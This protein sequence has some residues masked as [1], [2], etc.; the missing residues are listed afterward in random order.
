MAITVHI[1]LRNLNT[2]TLVLSGAPPPSTISFWQA[3]KQVPKR[4]K[5][6]ATLT[7]MIFLSSVTCESRRHADVCCSSAPGRYDRNLLKMLESISA[8]C[9]SFLASI[10]DSLPLST[11]MVLFASSSLCRSSCRSLS[12]ICARCVA[13]AL[14]AISSSLSPRNSISAISL[15]I[16]RPCLALVSIIPTLAYSPVQSSMLRVALDSVRWNSLLIRNTSRCTTARVRRAITPPHHICST[17]AALSLST[18]R[19]ISRP[20]SDI[21]AFSDGVQ[22]STC[23]SDAIMSDAR[24]TPMMPAVP[25]T[26]RPMCVTGYMSPYPTV[27]DVINMA[28]TAFCSQ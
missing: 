22:L 10:S 21:A 16:S 19:S 5:K 17:R 25:A 3:A 28:Q 1:V 9:L 8:W 27:V 2:S 11:A 6:V 26:K 23:D 4:P 12:D 18:I 7:A 14:F 24:S 20:T 15:A 13:L